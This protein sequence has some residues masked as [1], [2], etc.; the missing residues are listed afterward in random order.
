[1]SLQSQPI[2]IG[3]AKSVQIDTTPVVGAN[4]AERLGPFRRGS[5]IAGLPTKDIDE[6]TFLGLR[7]RGGV[8]Q[9]QT[10]FFSSAVTRQV[11]GFCNPF[12][13]RQSRRGVLTLITGNHMPF[14][15]GPWIRRWMADD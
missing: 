12:F 4:C 15:P 14:S 13:R 10:F 11:F 8:S 6:W 7:L 2:I 5:N 3:G 1:M 9:E